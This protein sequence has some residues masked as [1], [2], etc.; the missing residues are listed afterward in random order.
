MKIDKPM[1]KEEADK[2]GGFVPWVAGEYD[3]EVSEA[4]DGQSQ[5][6]GRDQIKLVL[7]VFNDEGGRRTVFD[8]L[9]SDEKSQWKVRHFCAAVGLIE[10]YESG[11]LEAWDCQ[12][13]TGRLALGVRAARGEYQ[14][15]NTV[16]DY[17][18]ADAP[19]RASPR[20]AA[21]A[22]QA[23]ARPTAGG[24]TG[25]SVRKPVPAGNVEDDDIP[26]AKQWQ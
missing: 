22:K 18:E 15:Q 2:G 23:A 19:A 12:G 13:R 24:S 7:W 4:E 10:K 5:S 26:F 16:R 20:P 6:S 3:F 1:T 8:Y 25:S 9:G 11:D 21:T 17:I 14:A